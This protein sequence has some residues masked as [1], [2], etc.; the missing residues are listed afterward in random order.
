MAK[1]LLTATGLEAKFK[2]KQA[3]AAAKKTRVRIPDGNNLYLVVRENGTASWQLL[4]TVDGKRKPATL[5]AYPNVTLKRARELAKKARDESAGGVDLVAKRRT[6]REVAKKAAKDE[7]STVRKMFDGWLKVKDVSDVYKGNITSAFIKDVFP[8]IGAKNPNEVTRAQIMEILRI[9]EARNSPVMLRRVKMYLAQMY[10]YGMEVGTVQHSPVPNHQLRSFI[11]G[12]KGHFPAVTDY[13]EVPAL[14]K[15]IASYPSPVVR[16]LM[17]LSAHLFQRPT[18]LRAAKWDEFDLDGAVWKLGGKR[19]KMRA[20]HWVPL[21]IQVVELLRVHQGIVGDEGWVF[22]GRRYDQPLSEG[23]VGEA[24][25]TLNYKGKHCHHG[26]RATARTVL[27]EHLKVDK[28]F[29]EKQLAHKTDD[30]G[31][32]GAYDRTKFWD[33]RIKLMQRWSDWVHAQMHV[34]PATDQPQPQSTRLL[35]PA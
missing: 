6:E 7:K 28:E 27:H 29:I 17:V 25:D 34:Q 16:N 4:I 1:E 9:I 12:E 24:L 30:S 22:P 14:F 8:A 11:V 21:S 19:M 32:D 23:A 2:A 15:A 5:G 3:E 35:I 33:D 10:E 20:E 26:F 31:L 18:E 13:N